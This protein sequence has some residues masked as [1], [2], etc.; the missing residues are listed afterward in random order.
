MQTTIHR[1]ETSEKE[2]NLS[3]RMASFGDVTLHNG[4]ALTL[5]E[6]WRSPTTIISDGPYGLGSFQGDP[7]TPE[8]LPDWYEPHI[9]AWSKKAT[10]ETT[11]WFWNSEVGW[12]TVHSL[13]VRNGWRYVN[14]H[15]WDKGKAHIA[16]NANSR[17]LRKFP[18]I[19]ELC[20]QYVR[21]VRI[22]DLTLKDWLRREWE[23]S[24]IPLSKS[25]E[26]SG[27][28]NAATRKY[29]TKDHLWYF[30]PP[31]AFQRIADYVNK[32]AEPSG[33]PYFSANGITPLTKHDWAKMRAKFHCE[34]GIS[35]VW[36]EP[37]LTGDERL[38]NGTQSAHLNQKPL[39]LMK[40][41]I[42]ASTDPRDLVWEPFGGLCSGALAALM[43][44]RKCVSAEINP[45]FYALAVE[46]L[47]RA[48]KQKTL[49]DASVPT[50]KARTSARLGALRPLGRSQTS[51]SE[52]A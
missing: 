15:V 44:K 39:S 34:V 31:E 49:I 26:A 27:V 18:V 45:S 33:R 35:N 36:R 41:I 7:H 13:L 50:D 40:L 32:F 28:D 48:R 17:T 16:G 6:K 11:L 37:P 23:R 4:D 43:L 2:A 20:V 21:D 42:E 5:Y 9:R 12:A 29:F 46:R 22:G 19:T 30:P 51:A 47:M 3:A 38:R 52:S 1:P 10:P 14:C 24:G 25:N 8:E